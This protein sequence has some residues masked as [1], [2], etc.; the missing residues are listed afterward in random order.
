MNWGLGSP[1][2]HTGKVDDDTC[3]SAEY[4]IKVL[5]GI[6]SF[7]ESEDWSQRLPEMR[8]FLRVWD[9]QRN[10]SFSDTFPEMADIFKDVK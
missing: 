9:R 10:N 5:D 7:M 8:E 4:G 3:R 1:S 2:G 6:L